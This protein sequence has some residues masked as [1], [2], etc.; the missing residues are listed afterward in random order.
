MAPLP[1]GRS[2]H[3]AIVLHGAV[4]VGGGFEGRANDKREGSNR[5]DVYNLTTNR[6][7]PTPIATPT[8]WF[9]MT[10][11][12]D[13]LIIAGGKAKSN[14]T[15][16]EVLVLDRGQW[17]CYSEMPTSRESATA[18]GY[19]SILIVVG[20]ETLIKDKWAALAT[21]ELL[22]TTNGCWYACDDLPVPYVQLKGEIIGSKL[23]LL[24]GVTQGSKVSSKVFTASLDNFS[25]HQLKWQSLPDTPWCHST[26]VV[27]FNKFLLT[28]GGR[29]P[30]DK[31]SQT[32]EV[33]AFN[34]STGVWE[35]IA[36][37]PV[38][39]SLLGVANV[40]D[41]IF[42]IMGGANNKGEYAFDTYIGLAY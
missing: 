17:N 36:N 27:L 24:H 2:A 42:I 33:C 14:K 11:L 8:F 4:Y 41:D 22:D 31:A 21:T 35:Q 37:A 32:S 7:D 23:Y 29:Q 25:S 5:L 16:N 34:P 20:G 19:R 12:D 30:S 26:P 13:K 3:T 28:V 18:V 39:R 15:T 10:V 6:W 9:A 40:A 1:V 38:A